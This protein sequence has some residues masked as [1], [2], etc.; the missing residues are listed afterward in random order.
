VIRYR[1]RHVLP[2]TAP[3]ITD[4]VVAVDKGRIAYV[5]HPGSAPP[6]DDEDLGNA[7]LLPGLVNTHC[8]LELTAFRGF[9]EGLD[10]ARWIVRLTRA[11]RDVFTREMLLDAARYGLA[12][13]VRNGITAYGD[14]CDSGVVFEALRE[15]GVRGIMYQEVFGPDPAQ[16][17]ASLAELREKVARMRPEETELVRVGV[18]PHAP[19]TVSDGLFRAVSEYAVAESLPMAIHIAESEWEQQLVARGAGPFADS[20]RKRGIAV[21]PRA[22]TPVDLID[23]LGVLRA[24]P[25]LIHCVRA[26]GDDVATIARTGCAVA[27]CPASNAKLGH[28]IAPLAELLAARVTVG[29]G[30]DSVASNNRMDLIDE[31]RLTVLM[32]RVR[33]LSPTALSPSAG[34]ELATFG[35]ARALGIAH[36][37]GSLE[38]G[39]AADLAAF[40][41]EGRGPVADPEASLFALAGT[42]ATF[43]SVG[44]GPL[45]RSGRLVDED[46]GLENRVRDAGD[47]LRA[48][49]AQEHEAP[50]A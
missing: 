21:A 11:R 24:R 25:L 12:E 20:H 14:T 40:S 34:W 13:G 45:V 10:F 50:S 47:R 32:Q 7:I 18:S 29:L 30:T 8:H 3:P 1:A 2:I 4:G 31:A 39:K 23:S 38:V 19:Y 16:C 37:V 15:R 9:L 17:A 36:E 27:H 41:L 43:V 22:R 28:G 33:E 42:P 49:L 26:D 46:H 5:G 35:G 6:G 44:G 48:W